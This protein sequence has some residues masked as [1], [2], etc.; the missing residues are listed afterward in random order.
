MVLSLSRS[1]TGLL[2]TRAHH[3]ATLLAVTIASLLA[4]SPSF[5]QTNP[6][7]PLPN[8]PQTTIK[9]QVRQVLFDVVVSDSTNHPVSGL[10][11][12]DFVVTEDGVPQTILSFEPRAALAESHTHPAQS[13]DLSHLPPNTFM[14][15]DRASDDLPL[16]VILFDMLNTSITDQPFARSSVKKFILHQPAG[17]RYAIFV[18]AD[19]LHLLQGVTG[20]QSQL[21]AALN[22][23]AAS[24]QTTALGRPNPDNVSPSTA[25]GDSGL[26]PNFAGPQAMLDRLK[27]LEGLG[28][29]YDL[30]RRVDLT[31]AA[32]AEIARFF[33][34][35]PGRK[36]L[37]WLSGSFP[38][39]TVPGE[40]PVDPFSRAVDFSPALRN[41]ST[42][43]TLSRVA[44]YPVDIRGL[45]NAPSFDSANNRVYTQSSL[46]T[47]RL[48]FSRTLSSEHATMDRVAEFTG[49]HAFYNTNG[50]E[51]ALHQAIL[52]GSSY[53]TLSYSPSNSKF[54][55]RLRKI[56]VRV[57][58]KNLRLAYR[59]TYFADDTSTVAHQLALAAQEKTA[60]AL[61]RGAPP[62]EDLLFSVHASLSGVPSAL[63]PAQISDLSRLPSFA[64]FK[65]WDSLTMQSYQLD[66]ALLRKQVTYR[67]FANGS[68]HAALQFLYAAYDADNALLSSGVWTGDQ[69]L[70]ASQRNLARTGM[71]RTRQLLDLPS[72]TSW[73]RI[74]VRDATDGR[75]GSLE[76]SL[77]LRTPPKSS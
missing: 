60:A 69:F 13:L 6:T 45:T 76:I 19:K 32:F 10:K 67:V 4:G 46:D 3:L 65:N 58:R 12:S 75:L 44:V 21:L 55:G 27:H 62:T 57:D 56:H 64:N 25:L 37:L 61:Q 53:Y 35:V 71:Y 17:Q 24:P 39:S 41:A 68:R 31:I 70:S 63:T 5:S 11:R 16:N 74:A 15:L 22:S 72:N 30:Q 2:V 54:D 29:T 47:D 14:N 40:D 20:D 73:L 48:D 52:D 51:Q 18:L 1:R 49:G 77:P 7:A 59:R 38:L 36:N 23:S 26:I 50:F 66:Y 9:T 42:Q 8:P 28:D 34:G 33:R 43:L